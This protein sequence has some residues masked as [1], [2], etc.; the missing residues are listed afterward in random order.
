MVIPTHFGLTI[1]EYAQAETCPGRQLALPGSCLACGSS[2]TL[3][4]WGTYWRVV[5]TPSGDYLLQIQRVRCR[6][7]IVQSPRDS[8]K[9]PTSWHRITLC[10]SKGWQGLRHQ[11][12]GKI[13]A[14]LGHKRVNQV[15]ISLKMAFVD[16]RKE[17]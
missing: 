12:R 5:Y 3:Q 13:E 15:I 6:A 8:Q 7:C 1:K 11:L 16:H 4:W 2:H 10:K 14:I 17:N 9:L